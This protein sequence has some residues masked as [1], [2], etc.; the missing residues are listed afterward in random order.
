MNRRNRQ[1][2]SVLHMQHGIVRMGS[3]SQC[4]AAR[5]RRLTRKSRSRAWGEKRARRGAGIEG[6]EGQKVPFR[7][8][9]LY[10]ASLGP[11][12]LGESGQMFFPASSGENQREI[13]IVVP[14]PDSVPKVAIPPTTSVC[15]VAIRL[16]AWR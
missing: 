1:D 13:R 15:A 2:K 14:D 8:S 3:S 9:G 16:L 6:D 5:S 11:A 12:G 7:D 4:E 10:H